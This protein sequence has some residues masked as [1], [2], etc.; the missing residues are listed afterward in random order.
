VHL[1]GFIIKKIVT[2]QHG[3]VNVKIGAS[4]WFYY[5]EICYDAARSR[6]RKNLTTNIQ[7]VFSSV[8]IHRFS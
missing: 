5:K 4:G 2:M 6:E 3:D 8:G 7:H 1:V